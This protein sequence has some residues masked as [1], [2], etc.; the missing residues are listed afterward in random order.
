MIGVTVRLVCTRTVDSTC[1]FMVD[2]QFLLSRG[3]ECQKSCLLDL[4]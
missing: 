2:E 1:L 3:E 4:Y